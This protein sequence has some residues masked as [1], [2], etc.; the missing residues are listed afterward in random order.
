MAAVAFKG[1]L[2]F[3]SQ[4]GRN[5]SI[6]VTISD[7]NGEFYVPPDG[8]NEIKLPTGLGQI[9]LVDLM[10]APATGTD[11]SQAEIYVNSVN[12]GEKILNASG[13]FDVIG[14]QFS[15]NPLILPS[16]ATLKIKQ[17]T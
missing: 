2:K 12:T 6:P 3:K 15:G 14:R 16:G 17:L 1:I 7:V 10:F 8:G 5:F 13:K 11:T 4:A 9:A